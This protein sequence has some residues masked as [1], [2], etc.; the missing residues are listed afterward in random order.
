[1]SHFVPTLTILAALK[2]ACEAL[3]L[4]IGVRLF[5][6]VDYFHSPD[7]LQALK[8]LHSFKKRACFLVPSGDDFTNAKAGRDLRSDCTRE[9]IMLLTDQSVS[10]ATAATVGDSKNPGVVLIKDLVIESLLGANLALQPVLVRLRPIDGAPVIISLE[11]QPK[12]PGRQA[13]QITWHADAGTTSVA[14]PL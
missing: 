11:D 6:R 9:F 5:D 12:A 3:E 4:S 2:T 8:Q 14:V 7:L 1:M 13:W 10:G